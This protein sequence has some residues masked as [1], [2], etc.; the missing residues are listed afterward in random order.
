LFVRKADL[1]SRQG[2]QVVL[3]SIGFVQY[4][5]IR[6]LHA[7]ANGFELQTV[8]EATDC[9]LGKVS[10]VTSISDTLFGKTCRAAHT[11]LHHCTVRNNSVALHAQ[12]SCSRS[13]VHYSDDAL[14]HA[15]VNTPGCLQMQQFSRPRSMLH[16]ELAQPSQ[17]FA[18]PSA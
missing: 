17:Q 6:G 2:R 7:C 12:Q 3:E 16:V 5:A 11:V 15:S 8:C 13:L 14:L 18:H 4:E 1:P 10:N 9:T